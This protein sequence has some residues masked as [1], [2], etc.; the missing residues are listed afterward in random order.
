MSVHARQIGFPALSC[1]LQHTVHMLSR[2]IYSFTLFER[3]WTW[4]L[5]LLIS[6]KLSGF[7]QR[8]CD[9]CW[10]TLSILTFGMSCFLTDGN[11]IDFLD[12]VVI[13]S[14]KWLYN[15][16][17]FSLFDFFIFLIGELMKIIWNVGRITAFWNKRI[18]W[19]EMFVGELYIQN[20]YVILVHIFAL[21]R[22]EHSYLS[23]LSNNSLV[24]KW[25][26]IWFYYNRFYFN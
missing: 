20:I 4:K 19:L 3:D 14:R 8:N 12:T 26:L 23:Y 18:V 16:R 7:S 9:Y 17:I 11:W 13:I 15:G 21:L 10:L 2:F 1:L 5:S 22:I 6:K 25:T 24:I